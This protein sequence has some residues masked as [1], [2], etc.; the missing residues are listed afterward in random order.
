MRNGRGS[1]IASKIIASL[2]VVLLSTVLF[3]GS[4]FISSFIVNQ[5]EN[6]SAPLQS[7]LGYDCRHSM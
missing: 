5:P 6:L 4:T 3:W 2:I 1:L 7:V